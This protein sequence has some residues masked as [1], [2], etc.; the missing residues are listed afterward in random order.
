[1]SPSN[2]NTQLL[3]IL[4]HSFNKYLYGIYYVP[5]TM[6]GTEIL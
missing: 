5:G 1:M 4:I 2:M 6:L 3:N